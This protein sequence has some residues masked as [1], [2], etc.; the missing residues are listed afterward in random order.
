MCRNGTQTSKRKEMK[1]P[2][3]ITGEVRYFDG[4][5]WRYFTKPLNEAKERAA[6]IAKDISGEVYVYPSNKHLYR[7][8]YQFGRLMASGS[9]TI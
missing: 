3:I 9:F 7:F 2:K 1:M 8:T 5:N 6:E 4:N